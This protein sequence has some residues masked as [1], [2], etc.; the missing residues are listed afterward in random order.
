MRAV[1]EKALSPESW[2]HLPKLMEIADHYILTDMSIPDMMEM[3]TFARAVPKSDQVFV[4]MPGTFAGNGDWLVSATDKRRVV[5]KMMGYSFVTPDRKDIRITIENASSTPREGYR[6]QNY[7]RKKGYQSYVKSV[8]EKIG[9]MARTRIVAQRAN[10]DEAELVKSDLSDTGDVVNASV[11]DIE[12]SVTIM[13]GDDLK[14]L[15]STTK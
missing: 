11:G 13:V 8:A 5:S 3:A 2:G 14:S 9:P 6:L 12:S 15:L 7:L 1:Q 4:M 10:P